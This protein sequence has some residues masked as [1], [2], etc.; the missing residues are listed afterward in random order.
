M[1]SHSIMCTTLYICKL[2]FVP[3][4]NNDITIKKK[5]RKKRNSPNN[6]PFLKDSNNN[7]FLLNIFSTLNMLFLTTV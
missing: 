7:I 5:K 3:N 1:V 6:N 4:N 2:S